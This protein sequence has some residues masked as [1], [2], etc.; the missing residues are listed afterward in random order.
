MQKALLKHYKD[1]GNEKLYNMQLAS[2]EKKTGQ[3]L[4]AIY[5]EARQLHDYDRVWDE[6]ESP[7]YTIKEGPVTNTTLVIFNNPDLFDTRMKELRQEES[8]GHK[9]REFFELKSQRGVIVHRKQ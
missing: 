4:D 5:E 7:V 2:M 8:S 3:K 6:S 1:I 9:K